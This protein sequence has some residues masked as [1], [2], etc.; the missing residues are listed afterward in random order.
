MTEKN[1]RKFE[2]V[3]FLYKIYDLIYLLFAFNAVI[4]GM[5]FMK[6]ATMAAALWGAVMGVFMLKDY[7]RYL[8]VPNLWILLAFLLSAA[9]SAVMNVRYGI[10]ENVEGLVWLGI[11]FIV[12]YVSGCVLDKE[13]IFKEIKI[14]SVIL[15]AYC[16]CVHAVSLSMIV[17]GRRWDYM[18]MS[19]MIHPIGYRWGRLW[20][21]YDDP[22]RGSVIALC[23]FFL[24]LY[25]IRCTKNK[26]VKA[27]LIITMLIQYLYVIFSDSRTG[28][29]SLAAGGFVLIGLRLYNR[30]PGNRRRRAAVSFL[31]AVFVAVGA[32]GVTSVSKDAYNKVDSKVAKLWHDRTGNTK[33]LEVKKPIGRKNDLE[34]DMS[35]GRFAIW[36]SGL[37]IA[38]SSPIYGVSFRNMTTYAKENF[39][40]CYLVN[41][42]QNGNYDSMHN[43]PLDILVSQGI[44]G[45]FIFLC[46]VG[47]TIR[48]LLRGVKNLTDESRYPVLALFS[49]AAAVAAAGISLTIVFYINAPESFLFWLCLGYLMGLMRDEQ[50]ALLPEEESADLAR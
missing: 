39:P 10:T 40:D 47:N 41:N 49:T 28:M 11:F 38:K 24:A 35:N 42:P 22:N 25:L 29:V 27:L 2:Q 3:L 16:T 36:E 37:Q 12:V 5:A 9:F 4:N 23:A 46:L 15:V 21:L 50:K 13:Q 6:Y 31:L 14:L 30:L 48:C 45:I 34:K 17:W 19:G 20:G 32:I 26:A 44:L 43:M 18:D 8:R 7:R 1:F 33:Q